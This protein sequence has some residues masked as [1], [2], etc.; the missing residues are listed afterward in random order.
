MGF[1]SKI[2]DRPANEK[3]FLVLPVGYPKEP[4]YVPDIKRKKLEDIAEFFE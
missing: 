3:P 1:L 2:L 4:L